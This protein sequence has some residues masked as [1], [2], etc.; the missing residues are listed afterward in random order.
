MDEDIKILPSVR[1]LIHT[2]L[3][4]FCVESKGSDMYHFFQAFEL[5]R[6]RVGDDPLKEY[7][8]DKYSQLNRLLKRLNLRLNKIKLYYDSLSTFDERIKEKRLKQLFDD[9][10]S[11]IPLISRPLF[12]S[13]ELLLKRT[14]IKFIPIPRDCFKAVDRKDKVLAFSEPEGET[15]DE[16]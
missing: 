16:S 13:F 15:Q 12:N 1:R 7:Y 9:E 3:A 2:K 6:S 11:N 14:E 10:F 4:Q 5:L 8:K